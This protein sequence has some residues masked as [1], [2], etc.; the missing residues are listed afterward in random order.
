MPLWLS[1]TSPLART[2]QL[3]LNKKCQCFWSSAHRTNLERHQA[4]Q[5]NQ[6]GGFDHSVVL[7]SKKSIALSYMILYSAILKSNSLLAGSKLDADPGCPHPRKALI[8]VS[9]FL[10]Y[11]VE[12]RNH[13]RRKGFDSITTSRTLHLLIRVD[14]VSPAFGVDSRKRNAVDRFH[15]VQLA[16]LPALPVASPATRSH[17]SLSLKQMS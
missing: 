16:W 15:S 11:Q 5:E 13:Q 17:A 8:P 12:I 2:S 10:R 9:A 7:Y 1:A 3:S 6:T 4:L 14:Q